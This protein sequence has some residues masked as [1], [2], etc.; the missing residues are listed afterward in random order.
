MIIYSQN[1]RGLADRRKTQRCLTQYTVSA[2]L[3]YIKT[4]LISYVEREWDVEA[5]INSHSRNRREV[6]IFLKN[7]FEYIIHR[8]DKNPEGNCLIIY[9]TIEEVRFSLA[10]IYR[11]NTDNPNF[12]MYVKNKLKSCGNADNIICGDWNLVMD[13]NKDTCIWIIKVSALYSQQGLLTVI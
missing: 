4:S 13:P 2:R 11:P 3:T 10:N 7:N 6:W 12:Y 8:L 5:Y 1:C 9:I